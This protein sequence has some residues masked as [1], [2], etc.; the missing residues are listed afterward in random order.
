MERTRIVSLT[1]RILLGDEVVHATRGRG[2]HPLL[3]HFGGD[4]D[5]CVAA[6]TDELCAISLLDLA[7]AVAVAMIVNHLDIVVTTNRPRRRRHWTAQLQ[8][9]QLQRMR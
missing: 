7:V 2:G 9:I 3:K 1:Q 8:C 6:D 4:G 5:A